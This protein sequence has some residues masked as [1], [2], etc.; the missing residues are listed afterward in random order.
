MFNSVI[1]NKLENIFLVF[2]YVIEN[3]LENKLLMFYF[4]QIY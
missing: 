2:S 3:E 1:E 4:S